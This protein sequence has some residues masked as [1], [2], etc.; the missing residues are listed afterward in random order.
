MGSV[1]LPM[2]A[3]GP[4]SV[5]AIGLGCMNLSHAYGTPPSREQAERVLLAA[6]DAGVTL[7][8]TAALYGFG[9]NETL[10]GQVLKPYRSKITLASKCG[11]HGADVKGDGKLQR[12]IDGRPETLK[13]TWAHISRAERFWVIPANKSSRL[14]E[15]PLT[16]QVLA[17]LELVDLRD[18]A[19]GDSEVAEHVRFA[20]GQRIFAHVH[21]TRAVGVAT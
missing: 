20:E 14:H 11:M 5:S 4:F 13:A 2:R 9:A 8:D 18:M 17:L 21:G 1:Q 7:F 15:L 19:A 3:L 10:L 16:P 12:V 6:L